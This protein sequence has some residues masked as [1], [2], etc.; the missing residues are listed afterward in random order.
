MQTDEQKAQWLFWRA[1]SLR[2]LGVPEAAA[3]DFL[4]VLEFPEGVVAPEMRAEALKNYLEIY[5]P[6]PGPTETFTPTPTETP[7]S[8]LTP[9]PSPTLKATA[10]PKPSATV[11]PTATAGQ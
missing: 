7:T 11:K 1:M 9:T 4:K 6:T 3:R 10:T 2:E 8:T 5:T